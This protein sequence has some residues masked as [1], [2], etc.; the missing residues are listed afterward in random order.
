MSRLLGAYFDHDI[1]PP[2]KEEFKTVLEWERRQSERA[3][4]CDL[5]EG[6]MPPPPTLTA[7]EDEAERFLFALRH[8]EQMRMSLLTEVMHHVAPKRAI[9]KRAIDILFSAAELFITKPGKENR[10][11]KKKCL[12][13]I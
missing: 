11:K 1:L 9:S 7:S 8:N 3:I 4:L 10:Q 13:S 6:D 12:A 5:F 2:S